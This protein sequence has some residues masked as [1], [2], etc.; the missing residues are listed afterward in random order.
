MMLESLEKSESG[1]SN[2]G[3]FAIVLLEG[4]A[5]KLQGEAEARSMWDFPTQYEGKGGAGGEL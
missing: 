5:Q 4:K 1:P 3:G 2:S